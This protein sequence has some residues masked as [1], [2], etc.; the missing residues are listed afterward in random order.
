MK[1][2]VIFSDEINELCKL[3]EVKT[4]FAFGSVVHDN[5]KPFSDIDLLVDI[6][7]KDPLI[8]SDHYFDLKFQLEKLLQRRIDLLEE[9]AIRNPFLKKQIDSDKVLLYGRSN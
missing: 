4:L 7:A 9:K 1:A 8:Y 6:D 5:L 2:L 3:H